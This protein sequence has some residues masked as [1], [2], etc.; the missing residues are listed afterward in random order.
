[1]LSRR[2][3]R[4]KAI[5]SL[6]SHICSGES[7]LIKSEKEYRHNLKKCYD[8]YLLMFGVIVE[9]SDYAQKRIDIGL[10]KL[11]PTEQ[12]KNPNMRFVNNS[13]IRMI[14]ESSNLAQ[15]RTRERATW[16]PNEQLVRELYNEMV[17]APYFKAYMSSAKS[18]FAADKKV[19]LDFYRNHIEDNEQFEEALEESSIFWSDDTNFVLGHVITTLSTIGEGDSDIDVQSMYKNDDDRMY[20]E[21]LYRKA[22]VN[23]DEYF[24]YIEKFAENWDFERIALMDKIIMLAAMSE[25][26]EFQSI[27]VK[28]TMDE[29]IEI[30][31]YYSTSGSSTFI[32][33]IIDKAIEALVS[34]GKIVKSG[35]GLIDN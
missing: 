22:L 32:N 18:S 23:S 21:M 14:R 25:L 28:V 15:A 27:P 5:K 1:M 26:I 10:A 17:E 3:I 8:L 31:K 4:I 30:S 7:S 33:G 2:L 9:V 35:R 12:D 16:R 20:A 19:V 11:R 24:K 34:E 6:Y 29:F 13:L